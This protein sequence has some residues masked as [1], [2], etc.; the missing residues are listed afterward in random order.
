MA[1]KRNDKSAFQLRIEDFMKMADQTVRDKP[2]MP[3]EEER[4]LRAKLILEEAIETCEAL[5]VNVFL[6]DSYGDDE[7]DLMGVDLEVNCRFEPLPP[8]RW[9][10]MEEAV[11][12]CCDILV[13]TIGTLSCL[14]VKDGPVMEEVLD[15][16]DAKLGGPVRPDGK[17]G[18]PEGWKPPN[19]ARRLH[20]QG[21]EG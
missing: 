1:L 20:E 6:G 18:K 3:T 13:V 15:A 14:G 12:G 11:D 4:I 5:G 21:W 8:D 16:N 19:I 2:E 10:D 7:V 9:F 17:K